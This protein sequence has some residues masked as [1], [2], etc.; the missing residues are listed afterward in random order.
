M[1]SKLD[2]MN[3]NDKISIALITTFTLILIVFITLL[4]ANLI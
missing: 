1:N 3:T 4:S 2:P